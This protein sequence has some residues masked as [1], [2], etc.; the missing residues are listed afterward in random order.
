MNPTLIL[1]VALVALGLVARENS[2][3]KKSTDSAVKEP[4]TKTDSRVVGGVKIAFSANS[5]ISFVDSNVA[6]G[7]KTFSDD[8]TLNDDAQVCNKHP[9]E[10]KPT[11]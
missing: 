4:A 2:D 6:N 11:A 3:D 7:L 8:C 1:G 10:A 5:K 9:L